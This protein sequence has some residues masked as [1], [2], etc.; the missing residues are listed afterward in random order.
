MKSST[1]SGETTKLSGPT[2]HKRI[3]P[4]KHPET[5]SPA[6]GAAVTGLTFNGGSILESVKVYTIFLGDYW[7]K[8]PG[9]APD[10]INKFFQYILTSALMDQLKEFN[11]NGY[12]I[13]HGSL[14]GTTTI[15]NTSVPLAITD[16]QIQHILEQAILD[17]T[18]PPPDA[19]TLYFIYLPDGVK[20]SAFGGS[21]CTEFC[22]YHDD[23]NSNPVIYYAVMP[24]PGCPGCIG[25]LNPF[26]ALTSTSSHELV[27]A[28]TDPV[29]GQGWYDNTDNE[30]IGDLCAWKTKK[31]G[32]YTVQLEWSNSARSCK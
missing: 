11:T 1:Q 29:P 15:T 17:H 24:Y 13:G 26:D 31:V 8:N 10:D 25:G 9:I 22:G 19:N 2:D 27:E 21:N 28:I 7:N 14:L 32:A 3:A 16:G 30:E 5:V 23:F 6:V 20:V 12:T 4:L 18:V